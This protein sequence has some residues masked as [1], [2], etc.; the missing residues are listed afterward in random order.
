ME[1][2][3]EA[4][5]SY[6]DRYLGWVSMPMIMWTDVV[7]IIIISFLVYHVLVWIKNTK[8]WSL[9]R[10]I[11][12]ILV[13]VF[14]AAV[15]DMNTILWIAKNVTGIAVTALLIV[16]QPELRKALEQLGKSN[17]LSGL[18]Q[19]DSTRVTGELFSDKTIDE[20]VRASYE[21]G[22]VKTGALIVIQNKDL[23]TEYELTGIMV[24]ALVSSQLLINIFEHNTP[25][26]DGAVVIKGNRIVA[27]TCYLPLSD[28]MELSK[29]LGTRHRAGVG[30]SEATDSLTIIVSEE[31]G[32]V[33]VAM[34]GE[35]FRNVDADFLRKKLEI[36]QSKTLEEKKLISFWKG[37]SR[38]ETKADK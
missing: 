2:M 19:F 29:E 16:F 11:V 14:I 25:L 3:G 31:T 4:I 26:H 36:L 37:R 10:G 24:D 23:L 32:R 30:I 15:F 1:Q 13:F 38:N 21:M 34:N 18:V 20:L 33:S 6:A 27:A 8:A 35:L 5:R 9:M 22:K 12:I 28:N 17:V 7:E